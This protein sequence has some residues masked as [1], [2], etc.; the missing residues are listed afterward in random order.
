MGERE[1]ESNC[2]AQVSPEFARATGHLTKV[3]ELLINEF[4]LEYEKYIVI[5]LSI[6]NLRTPLTQM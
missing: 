1:E 5:M 2:T 6:I 4:V 3:N